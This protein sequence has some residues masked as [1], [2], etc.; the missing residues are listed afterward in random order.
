MRGYDGYEAQTTIIN[1]NNVLTTSTP[2][3]DLVTL[4]FVCLTTFE[5]N[6]TYN[7]IFENKK[8]IIDDCFL[9]L[10]L[11]IYFNNLKMRLDYSKSNI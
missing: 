7:R 10:H 4:Q 2:C 3:F 6:K 8:D 11:N 1:G 9:D 5:I